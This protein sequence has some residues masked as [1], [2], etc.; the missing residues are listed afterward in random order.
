MPGT[1]TLSDAALA[2]LKLHMEREGDIRVDNANRE[3][4]REL[5]GAG[6]MLAGYSFRDGRGVARTT[7][8]TAAGHPAS[9]SCFSRHAFSWLARAIRL[10]LMW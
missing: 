6:L 3:L 1:I 5:A 9:L 8:I 4:Y 7:S 2:L 10:R